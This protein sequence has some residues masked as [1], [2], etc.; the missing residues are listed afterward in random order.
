MKSQEDVLCSTRTIRRHLHNEKIKHKKKIHR[1]RLTMKHKEKRLEYIRQYQT[2]S[3]KEKQKVVLS[4]EKKFYLEGSDGFQNYWDANNFS[5]ENYS[6]RH[7]R[8]GSFMNW[9]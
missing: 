3:A 8:R 1:P 5:V 9:W 6:R 7:S 4:D 2:M